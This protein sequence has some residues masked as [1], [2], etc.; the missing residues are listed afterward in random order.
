M[1]V[2]PGIM[3]STLVD[4]DG[5]QVWGT[6]AGALLRAVAPSL[7]GTVKALLQPPSVRRRRSSA[8]L[9]SGQVC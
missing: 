4:R 8:G 3:G 2:L 1:A 5:R 6:S 7:A 9:A